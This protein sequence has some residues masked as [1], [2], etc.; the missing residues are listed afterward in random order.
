[1]IAQIKNGK[2]A[3]RAK[4][5]LPGPN[6]QT[7]FSG[8]KRGLRFPPPLSACVRACV[9]MR[10]GCRWP[11]I[12]LAALGYLLIHDLGLGTVIGV[13]CFMPYL[14]DFQRALLKD[15]SVWLT[16]MMEAF[17]GSSSRGMRCHGME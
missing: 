17:G 14:W 9:R 7:L 16:V 4:A 3:Q 11:I 6:C 5:S 12:S 2:L 13:F 15:I 10:I 8:S 1:M